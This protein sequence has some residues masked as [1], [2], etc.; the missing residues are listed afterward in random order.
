MR[1]GVGFVGRKSSLARK[2]NWVGWLWWAEKERKQAGRQ[3]GFGL[4]AN[5][6]EWLGEM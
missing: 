3:G 4:E 6:E 5:V 1:S 2:T